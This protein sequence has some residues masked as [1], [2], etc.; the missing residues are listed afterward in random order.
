MNKIFRLLPALAVAFTMTACQ[1]N[2]EENFADKARI[3][4]TSMQAE[5]VIKGSEGNITKTLTIATA[6]PA[7]KTITAT[8]VV[9]KNLVATY[10]KA[11][12]ADAELLPDENYEINESKMTINPGSVK[13]SEASFTFKNLGSLDRSKV[14]VLPVTV[15]TSDID[16]IA[17]E[18]NYYY[19]FKAGALIN[20]VADIVDNYLEIYPWANVDRVRGMKQI[21]MEA[22]IYPRTLDKQISTVMGIE[23]QFLMRIGDAGVPSNQIQIATWAGNVTDAKLQLQTN[24][25]THV[26]MTFDLGNHE[27]KFYFN[28]KLVYETSCR[29]SSVNLE[30]DGSDRNFLIGKSY[31]DNRDFDGY[32]SEVRLWDVVRTKEEIANNIYTVDP[33]SEGLVAYWKFDEGAGANV[34]DASGNGNTL[35]AKNGPLLWHNVSLPA[36]N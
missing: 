4:A 26:A 10:N 33:T 27:M 32:I 30:G 13:S 21:T 17:S 28:G 34:A 9:D 35:K 14:F 11:Y 16:M 36:S 8:A 3:D 31:D 29:T 1:D 18:K 23:G 2:D 24:T 22:L 15:Q 7:E 5:T 20:V 6:R 12:Y 19:V 25:W